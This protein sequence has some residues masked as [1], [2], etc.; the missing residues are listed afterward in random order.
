MT[1][2]QILL[3]EIFKFD[4]RKKLIRRGEMYIIIK[5]CLLRILH[6]EINLR[7]RK[8]SLAVNLIIFQFS[9]IYLPLSLEN[10]F[11][12]ILNVLCQYNEL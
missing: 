7:F 5:K 2:L 11:A 12:S 9:S 8:C 10:A 3:G 6:S 4:L 1:T